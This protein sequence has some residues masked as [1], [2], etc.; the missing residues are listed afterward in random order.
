MPSAAAAA[1]TNSSPLLRSPS[2]INHT[3]SRNSPTHSWAAHTDKVDLPIP[4][5]P[6]NV[7][8]REFKINSL[9]SASSAGL[10]R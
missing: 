5:I 7:T 8:N 10:S 4:P 9:S 2:S 6:V 1:A 3:P